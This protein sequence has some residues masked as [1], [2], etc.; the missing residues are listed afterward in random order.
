MTKKASNRAFEAKERHA[1]A[2]LWPFREWPID[3]EGNHSCLSFCDSPFN[4]AK[5]PAENNEVIHAGAWS[6]ALDRQQ[7]CPMCPLCLEYDYADLFSM[8]PGESTFCFASF[9]RVDVPAAFS[10]PRVCCHCT[11]FAV[12]CSWDWIPSSSPC[13][14]LGKLLTY[15]NLV[16]KIGYN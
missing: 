11:G 15:V 9:W 2:K 6:N 1:D 14:P 10:S 3:V 5:V 16:C 12:E 4:M 8:L 7:V 13:I